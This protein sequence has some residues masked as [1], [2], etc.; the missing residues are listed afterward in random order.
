MKEIEALPKKNIEG[1]SNKADS[2]PKNDEEI[3]STDKGSKGPK[4]VKKI[5]IAS[6]AGVVALG[7]IGTGVYFGVVRKNNSS[8]E[9][10]VSTV[11]KVSPADLEQMRKIVDD[12]NFYPGITINGQSV[13]GMSKDEVLKK[14]ASTDEVKLDIQFQVGDEKVPLKTGDLKFESNAEAVIEEAYNYGRTSVF[15]GDDAIVD[16]FHTIDDLSKT[17]K[18]YT[19][20]TSLNIDGVDIDTLVRET[21]SPYNTELVEAQL[22]DF[23]LEKLE[24]EIT[25]SQKGCKVDID[26]AIK[27]VK[28]KL[29]AAEYQTVITVKAEITE[30]TT[31]SDDLKANFGM[32][33]TTTSETTSNENRNTNIRLICEKLDGLVLQPGEQ[34]NFND[35]IGKRTEEKGYKMAHG[36][37]NGSMR[38]ELGGGI[39]Q[40]NT[41]LYQ[42]VTKADLQ[43]D[44]RKNHSIPSTYVDKGTDATVTWTSPNFRFTN[45]TEYPIAIHAVYAD[46]KVTVAVY[47][48]LLP[49]GQRIELV[50]EHVRTISA[51]TTY[52]ADPTLAAGTKTTVTS[53]RTGYEYKSYK[54]WYDKDG[55]EIKKEPYFSS[56]YPARDEVVHVGTLGADGSTY[57][58]DPSGNLGDPVTTPTPTPDPNAPANPTPTPTPVPA[59]PNTPPA[60]PTPTPA[61]ADPTPTPVPAAPTPT[62]VPADPTPTPTPVPEPPTPEP[63]PPTPEPEPPTPEPEPGTPAP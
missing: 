25:E 6:V 29:E 26:Q 19:F 61:P 58:M 16:R 55:N 22:G 51:S 46:Q 28:A 39:C 24:F 37:F 36:I 33:A 52:V 10:A 63:E 15:A 11:E 54:V 20:T 1:T 9:P 30:P 18:D 14:F 35:Y 59:D 57:N 60:N 43:V 38:D 53:G 50:G 56:Y 27:D 8:D 17:P 44:E 7:A 41:M 62:P 23:N 13:A 42:S 34:F 5:I 2:K 31:S 12:P 21:L 45:N 4:N 48:R 3:T 32:I 40:A 49:D 47:G